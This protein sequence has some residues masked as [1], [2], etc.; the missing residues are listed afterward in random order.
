MKTTIRTLAEGDT[1][2]LGDVE[3]S[4]VERTRHGKLQLLA[5][6]SGESQEY[7]VITTHFEDG[8]KIQ[9]SE[10]GQILAATDG[11]GR[12]NPVAWMLVPAD[13]YGGAA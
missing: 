11:G 2:E 7:V 9:V 3:A 8:E 6:H 12:A 10:G 4:T 1:V 13:S 5:V